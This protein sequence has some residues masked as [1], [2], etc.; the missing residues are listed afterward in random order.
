MQRALTIALLALFERIFATGHVSKETRP[1]T[2]L[3][4]LN[5]L[6]PNSTLGKRP[7]LKKKKF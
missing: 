4:D 1:G 5:R 3:L 6:P 7:L 2:P